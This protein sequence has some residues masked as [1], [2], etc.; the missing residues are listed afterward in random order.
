[1]TAP[2]TVGVVVPARDEVDGIEACLASILAAR[3]PPGVDLWVV[4]AADAC[5]DPTAALAARCVG[6]AGEVLV[7]DHGNVGAARRSATRAVLDRLGGRSTTEDRIWLLTTD[8]DS[9]VSPSWI[10]SHLALADRGAAAVAGTV[11]V[12]DFDEQHHSVPDAYR[13][14]YTIHPDGTHPHVH[15]ANLGVRADAYLDVGGWNPLAIAEDH[16]LWSRI[17]AAGFPVVSTVAAPVLTSGRR[18]GRAP[19]GFA[20]LLVS[21]GDTVAEGAP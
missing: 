10:T 11:D 14:R 1:M 3:R 21:L 8:A 4:V 19:K 20:S 18:D 5:H 13:R 17:R 15:G 9:T 7:V 12:L 2:W 16:D 6:P